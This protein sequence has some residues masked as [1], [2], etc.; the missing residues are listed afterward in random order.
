MAEMTGSP[1]T[2]LYCIVDINVYTRK[3]ITLNPKV[4][5]IL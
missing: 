3:L 2:R 4:I 1:L 5:I